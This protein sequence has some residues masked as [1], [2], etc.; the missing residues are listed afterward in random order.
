MKVKT[1]I[2]AGIFGGRN[3]AENS[4]RQSNSSRIYQEIN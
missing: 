1:G 4:A 3:E 2:K